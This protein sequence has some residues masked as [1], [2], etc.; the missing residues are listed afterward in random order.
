MLVMCLLLILPMSI[1][2]IEFPLS[3][4][5]KDSGIIFEPIIPIGLVTPTGIKLYDFL[6]DSG[7][8]FT[9]LPQSL[10]LELNI[11]LKNCAQSKTQ[12]IEGGSIIIYSACIVIQIGPWKEKIHCAFASHDHIP[13]LLGRLDVFSRYTITFHAKQKSIIFRK[14][15]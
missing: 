14:E 15:A 2:F 1:K 11:N 8:D 13:P 10:A 5:K 7:A 3:T 6:V 12:G 9:L 4:I